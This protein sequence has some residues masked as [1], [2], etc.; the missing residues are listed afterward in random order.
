MTD[1]TEAQPSIEL[2]KQTVTVPEV[3]ELLGLEP[4][5]QDKIFSPY[6]PD[7]KTPSCH[8]YDDHFWDFSSGK[9]GDVVDLVQAVDPSISWPR[10]VKMLWTRALQVGKEPGDVEQQPVRTV[11]DF[12]AEFEAKTR[13]VETHPWAEQIGC[14]L[15]ATVRESGE[16]LLIAHRDQDGI[17]GVKVRSI[18]GAKSSW[19]GSQFTKRLYHP[20]G[21]SYIIPGSG[22]AVITEGESDCW[23]VNHILAG[24]A[25]V[26]ALPSGA[27]SWKDE[28][29][30]DLE[31]YERIVL[32]MDNDRSGQQALDKLTRKIGWLRVEQVRV[33]QLYN[34]VREAVLAGW[35]GSSLI[36]RVRA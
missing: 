10:A 3:A 20:F 11:V 5:S 22:V 13:Y 18:D 32:I 6:N 8:L 29:L 24:T 4:N 34:D 31:P 23:H 19:P 25:E 7:E 30:K 27:Q 33:P 15:P 36:D 9:G 21:H 1:W 17:Y 28:W 12:T 14:S 26:F 16:G 35:D 2:V